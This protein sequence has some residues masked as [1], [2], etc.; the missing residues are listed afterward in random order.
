VNFLDYVGEPVQL[1]RQSLGFSVIAFL[2][3]FTL[4]AY[5]LKK[6]YWKDIK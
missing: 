5:A 3:F 2:V 4:L 1:K 6:E